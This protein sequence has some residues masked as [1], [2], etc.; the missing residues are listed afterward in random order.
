VG[1][2]DETH[3]CEDKIKIMNLPSVSEISVG[4]MSERAA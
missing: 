3:E 1:F 4:K 2:G